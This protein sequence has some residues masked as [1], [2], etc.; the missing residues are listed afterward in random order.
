MT[1]CIPCSPGSD[2]T[3]FSG[4]DH[5]VLGPVLGIFFIWGWIWPES[6]RPDSLLKSCFFSRCLFLCLFGGEHL[7]MACSLHVMTFLPTSFTNIPCLAPGGIWIDTSYS[8]LSTLG[9]WLSGEEMS[10]LLL[11][12][13]L[14][15]PKKTVHNWVSSWIEGSLNAP[16]S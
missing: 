15:R 9:K 13:H 7:Q 1:A 8:D 4:F 12:H 2:S 11:D 5:T 16:V 3:A 6:P 14:P 10:F